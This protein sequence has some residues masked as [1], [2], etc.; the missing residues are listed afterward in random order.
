MT[1][2]RWMSAAT[3]AALTLAAANST[4]VWLLKGPSRALS[5][6]TSPGPGATSSALA[7][8]MRAL[9]HR[10][11]DS[12][13]ITAGRIPVGATLTRMTEFTFTLLQPAGIPARVISYAVDMPAL[14]MGAFAFEESL[15]ASPTEEDLSAEQIV[16]MLRG[17]FESLPCDEFPH[18]RGAADDLFGGTADE[19]F[20]VG[21]DLLLRG[22]ARDTGSGTACSG[23]RGRGKTGPDD[24]EWQLT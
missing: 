2:P 19:R 20:E 4:T 24:R 7:R 14:Y 22:I 11:R 15:V 6:V 12:A 3:P 5:T 16:A 10:H 1:L 21:L 9:P 18:I 8:Q 23:W 13:R 17:H